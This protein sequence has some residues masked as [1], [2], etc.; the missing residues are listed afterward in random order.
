MGELVFNNPGERIK[1]NEIVH[2]KVRE[3]MEEKKQQFLNEGHN[4]IMDIPLFI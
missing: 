1:L 2:P 4:V 3:I